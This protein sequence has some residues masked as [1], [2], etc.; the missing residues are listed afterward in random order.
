MG[1]YN[2]S[3]AKFAEIEKRLA[4]LEMQN[5]KLLEENRIL[6]SKTEKQPERNLYREI[7]DSSKISSLFG[8][9]ADDGILKPTENNAKIYSNFQTF[10]TN[11]LRALKPFVRKKATGKA[12]YRIIG[13]PMNEFSDEEWKIAV[14]TVEA[15]VDTIYYAKQKMTESEF[16]EVTK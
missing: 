5:A 1:K 14:E 2:F 13:T 10:Y 6:N 11:V 3:A 9:S 8:F 4:D 16:K 15:V 12:G 7:K